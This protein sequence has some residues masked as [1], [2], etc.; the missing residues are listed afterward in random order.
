M[1]TNFFSMKRSSSSGALNSAAMVDDGFQY[2]LGPP[3]S[4]FS[5]FLAERTKKVHFIRHAEVRS[6]ANNDGEWVMHAYLVTHDDSCSYLFQ[7]H[8]D[9]TT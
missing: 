4:G 3:E 5:L 8:R 2:S 9:I 1:A 7:L 6:Y